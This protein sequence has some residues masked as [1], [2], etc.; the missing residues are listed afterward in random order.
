MKKDFV[1]TYA[2]SPCV[3]LRVNVSYSSL[4]DDL[5]LDSDEEEKAF[6][7]SS[8]SAFD[9]PVPAKKGNTQSQICIYSLA[10][11]NRR[12]FVYLH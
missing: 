5:K 12:T 4:P 2:P 6:S 11:L 9:K 10:T 7:Y 3:H 8:S 1:C